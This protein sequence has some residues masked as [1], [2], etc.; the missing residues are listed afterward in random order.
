MR[1]CLVGLLTGVTFLLGG[2]LHPVAEKVDRVVCDL[3][4]MPRDPQP[5]TPA[6]ATLPPPAEVP[7]KPPEAVKPEAVKPATWQ[8]ADKAD[9]AAPP[10]PKSPLTVPDQLLPGGHVPPITLPPLTPETEAARKAAI[11]KLSPPLL[12]LGEDLPDPVVP[13]GGPLSLA[14]LQ[15]LAVANSPLVKQAVAKV[16]EQRGKAIQAGLG[17]NPNFGF[18]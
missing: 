2:C 8:K 3:A 5:A 17:P 16:A 10:V 6:P 13:G 9:K 14:D 4:A 7:E 18:E 12:S 15:A 1:R 11:E